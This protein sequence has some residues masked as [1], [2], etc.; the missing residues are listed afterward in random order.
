[1]G[2]NPKT[3]ARLRRMGDPIGETQEHCPIEAQ[4]KQEWL[5]HREVRVVE[6]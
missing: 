1:L 2:R 4:G 6:E 3:H 5:C